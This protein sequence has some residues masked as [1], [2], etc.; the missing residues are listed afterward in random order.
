MNKGKT[1]I[2]KPMI[3]RLASISADRSIAETPCDVIFSD[4]RLGDDERAGRRVEIVDDPIK[5]AL[6][7]TKDN[8]QQT[9][10]A[11]RHPYFMLVKWDRGW[12]NNLKLWDEDQ[13]LRQMGG[14]ER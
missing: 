8:H 2:S 12:M 4:V 11:V 3:E 7:H 5:A 6:D 1:D 10:I 14:S 9:A 13:R